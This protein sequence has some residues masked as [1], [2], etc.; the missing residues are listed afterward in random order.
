MRVYKTRA[1]YQRHYIMM[2]ELMLKQKP[3][4]DDTAAM[5][6]WESTIRAMVSLFNADGYGK[7]QPSR[8][9]Q[10]SGYEMEK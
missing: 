6:Q 10:K 4:P 3:E 8:F 7:F 1:F 5:D 2:A 9:M